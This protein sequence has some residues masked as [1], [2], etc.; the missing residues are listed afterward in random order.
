[1]YCVVAHGVYVQKENMVP[2]SFNLNM[3]GQNEDVI[4]MF[5]FDDI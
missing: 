1:M 5:R 3:Q 2:T 4:C